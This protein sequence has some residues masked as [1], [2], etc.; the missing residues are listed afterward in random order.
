MSGRDGE[1]SFQA[2]N[3]T[4]AGPW[5]LAL[6]V[7]GIVVGVMAMGEGMEFVTLAIQK[8]VLG[9]AACRGLGRCSMF[10]W[11]HDVADR[12]THTHTKPI[13]TRADL[14]RMGFFPRWASCLVLGNCKALIARD[15]LVVVF[16]VFLG[17][18]LSKECSSVSR[19]DEASP[20]KGVRVRWGR[21]RG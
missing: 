19:S 21:L 16:L 10:T 9:K 5:R 13:S 3:L 14:A 17:P 11:V 15:S 20:C 18:S 7:E 6:A 12:H 1:F 8:V 4:S 2:A